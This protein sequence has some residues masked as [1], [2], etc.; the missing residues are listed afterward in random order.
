VLTDGLPYFYVVEHA[1]GLDLGLSLHPN[2]ALDTLRVGFNDGDPLSAPVDAVVSELS[3][4]AA[5]APADGATP[6]RAT[7]V[8]CDVN[9]VVLGSGLE[10]NVDPRALGPAGLDGPI[11]DHGDGRYTLDLVASTAGAGRLVVSVEGITL[12]SSP[13]LDYY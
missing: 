12:A 4:D 2:E 11:T 3:L 5:G 6:I 7:V 10:L 9:G 8:P 1:A 13:T